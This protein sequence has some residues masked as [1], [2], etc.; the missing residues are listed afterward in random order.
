MF[1]RKFGIR[2]MEQL[3]KPVLHS[4]NTFFLPFNSAVHYVP[5]DETSHGIAP[6]SIFLQRYK[7]MVMVDHVLQQSEHKGDPR[8]KPVPVNSLILRY[9]TNYRRARRVKEREM[10]LKDRKMLYVVNHA[11]APEMYRYLE[12][13]PFTPYNKWYNGYATLWDQAESLA[14]I[15]D[16][17]QFIELK[18][19]AVLPPP[20]L[21]MRA[22]QGMTRAL[23]AKFNTPELLSLLDVWLWLGEDTRKDSL[24]GRLSPENYSKINIVWFEAGRWTLLNLGTLDSW[25]ADGEGSGGAKL[26]PFAI[27]RRFLRLM[28]SITEARSVAG[29]AE[30]DEIEEP[31]TTEDDD[32]ERLDDQPVETAPVEEVG[33]VETTREIDLAPPA[34][35]IEQPVTQKRL[36]M[37]AVKTPSVVAKPKAEPKAKMS[38]SHDDD[39]LTD[40]DDTEDTAVEIPVSDSD[41]DKDLEQLEIMAVDA[42]VVETEATIQYTPYKPPADSLDAGVVKA[43]DAIAKKG[44][45]T[46]AEHRRFVKLS[47]RFKEIPNPYTKKGTLADL[48]VIKPEEV[49]VAQKTPIAESIKGVTD[50]SMLSSSLKDLDRRYLKE[51]LPKD[52]VSAVLNVQK[53]GVAVQNYEV[54]RVADMNDDFEVHSVKLTPV[55]GSPSTI[56]FRLPVVD[57]N[58]TYLSGGVRYK[59]RRQ[60]GDVPIR[61][62]APDEVALTSYYSKMFVGRSERAVFNYTNWLLNAVTA[63]GIDSN[64]TSITD[65]RMA[66]VF[67][68][69]VDVPKTY[70]ILARRFTGFTAGKYQM[71]FDYHKR[72]DFFGERVVAEVETKKVKLIPIGKGGDE[73][74]ML[75][76]ADQVHIVNMKKPQ[77]VRHVGD[78]E[79]LLGIPKESRPLEI[80]EVSIFGKAIPIAFILGHEVGLGNLIA[81]LGAKV[82]RVGKHERYELADNEYTVKFQDETLIFDRNDKKSA[83]IFGSLN[84]YHKDIK[85]YS[86]YLFDKREVYQIILDNNGL[87]ARYPREFDLMFKMWVD[88]ITK[89]ILE[90]MK[91]P[92]DLV[93]LLLRACEMLTTDQHPAAI[94]N[95]YMRDKGYERFAGLAYNEIV[96]AMRVYNSKAANATATVDLNPEAVWSVI[97]DDATVAVIEESNPIHN[98]KE[99]EVV[100][101]RGSGGRSARSMTADARVFHR[102]SMGVVSEAT[103]DSADVGTIVYLTADPNYKSLRGTI[104]PLD[105]V[106]GNASKLLSTSALLAVGSENDDWKSVVLNS[107]KIT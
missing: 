56:R 62:I 36:V 23:L 42:P 97:R 55:I 13:N 95:N 72:K 9:H 25:R 3:V 79:S 43:A 63:R 71:F 74:V 18:V 40:T 83:L 35:E 68:H 39:V 81:T 7:R 57:E 32:K 58:G 12:S 70:S 76:W 75:D 77:D 93:G 65:V 98:L 107:V 16:R 1:Y 82:R 46:A 80:A 6:D 84:R 20:T 50:D 105:T 48:T 27:Q 85:R 94:D 91:E 73:L 92:T 41:I 78:I 102:S 88:H 8:I 60:R 51:V 29:A 14:K 24:M 69:E 52:I 61:K 17:N 21:L 45:I 31:I 87:A 26:N 44:L 4:V 86:V 104:R 96:K 100:V 90:E 38:V 22:S 37:G 59:M 33:E 19:P 28:M 10:A 103:S 49:A 67:D 11:I 34:P 54:Q 30:A 99:K 53:A 101:Y 66:K 5:E 47:S 15:S 64:D 2:R 89:E 106:K